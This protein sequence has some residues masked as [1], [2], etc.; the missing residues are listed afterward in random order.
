[1]LS[2][3]FFFFLMFVTS[4]YKHFCLAQWTYQVGSKGVLLSSR[5]SHNDIKLFTFFNVLSLKENR[6]NAWYFEKGKS[7]YQGKKKN[8]P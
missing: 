5:E 7:G 8:Y 1:M 4:E 6:D 2:I 3:T